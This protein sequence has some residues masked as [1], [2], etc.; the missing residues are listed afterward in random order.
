VASIFGRRSQLESLFF[1][2]HG[3]EPGEVVI[4]KW[5]ASVPLGGRFSKHGGN[6]VVTNKRILFEPMRVPSWTPLSKYLAPFAEHEGSA[7]ISDMDRAEAVTGAPQSL[8]LVSATGQ[9]RDFLIFA[10]RFSTIWSG[11]NAEA[12]DDAVT[13]INGAIGA[14]QIA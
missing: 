9:V 7:S 1:E 2:T 14:H 4:R 12:L 6:L 11:S 5:V 3:L 13:A 10:H 8:R